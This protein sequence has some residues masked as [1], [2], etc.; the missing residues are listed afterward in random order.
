MKRFQEEGIEVPYNQLE[1]NLRKVDAP[2]AKVD[3]EKSAPEK[4]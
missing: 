3:I 2:V 4:V 1:I